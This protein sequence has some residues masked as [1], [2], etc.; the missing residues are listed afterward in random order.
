[1]A[2]TEGDVSTPADDVVP[3]PGPTDSKTA[4][5][6]PPRPWDGEPAKSPDGFSETRRPT[7]LAPLG[8]TANGAANPR[9]KPARYWFEYGETTA[10]GSK[11][12]PKDLGPKLSAHYRE[13]WNGGNAANWLGGVNGM[14][15]GYRTTG[16]VSG[17][18]VRFT[19]PSDID[20][21]HIDGIGANELFQY[22]WVGS[23]D[24]GGVA[25]S[26]RWGGGDPDLRDAKVS[27]WMR[28]TDWSTNGSEV[29]FW[30]QTDTDL[31]HQDDDNLARR[32][33]W[34]YTGYSLTEFLFSGKWEH[35]EYRIWNDSNSWSYS[36]NDIDSGRTSYVYQDL[37]TTL[38]HVNNDIFHMLVY[39]NPVL[40]RWPSGQADIDDF[41]ITYRNHSLLAPS[42][43]AKVVSS[44]P[45]SDD[46]AMLTDGWR[47]GA[48]RQWRSAANPTTPQ[49]IVYEL[50]QPITISRLQIHQNPDWPAKEI[51]VLVSADGVNWAPLSGTPDL[52]SIMPVVGRSGPNFAYFLD[53]TKR[54]QAIEI[55]STVSVPWPTIAAKRVKVR[56]KSGYKAEYW[57][58]GEIEAFGTGAVM[59]TD[60]DWYTLNADIENL[61]AGKTYHYRLAMETSSGITYAGDKTYVVPN[62]TRPIIFTRGAGRIH[63]GAAR[64]EGRINPMSDRT[65]FW[66]E[67]GQTTSY[68][69]GTTDDFYAGG[70][71]TPRDVWAILSDL[72]PGKTYHYRLVAQN[73][74][75]QTSVGE[76]LT[77]VAK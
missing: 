30:M 64:L 4:D 58:L 54:R 46:P 10:Y 15:L 34:A 47:Y 62:D 42:N 31:A 29:V 73:S 11:T 71:K 60:D 67:Y 51:E 49:E 45:G 17:G 43:G 68:E 8:F 37:D 41:E 70:Q 20:E 1:M 14:D 39:V 3:A 55:E 48:S 66:F 19:A 65:Q 16:G 22:M 50:A 76:D 61:V 21:N 72:V 44:P 9:G 33:N 57:G 26:A 56:I 18:N 36:G 2:C 35:A 53:D 59:E 69:L 52:P 75:G 74:K 24:P 6:P 28:G 12:S 40:G 27:V 38:A 32:T 23:Y 63:Q 7:A 25:Q 13:E 77:F 5:A